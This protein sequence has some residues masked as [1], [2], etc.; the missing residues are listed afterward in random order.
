MRPAH[1]RSA[2]LGVVSANSMPILPIM[3]GEKADPC[4]EKDDE[5]DYRDR[6][7]ENRRPQL[8]GLPRR[9]VTRLPTC[10]WMWRW[11]LASTLATPS[12]SRAKPS[13]A[14]PP[15]GRPSRTERR[16]GGPRAPFACQAYL[17]LQRLDHRR[18]HEFRHIAAQPGDFLDQFRGNRLPPRIGHQEHRLDAG[19]QRAV[20][21]DHLEFILE[22]RHRA[23]AADDDRRPP[24]RGRSRSAGSRTDARRSRRRSWR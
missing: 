12:G 10:R 5:D 22:I 23:Q 15:E 17:A 11:T 4:D 18:R 20:H 1:S 13:T 3:Q 2:A 19:I 9:P 24:H 16:P 7:A 14:R 8:C 21:A 6:H